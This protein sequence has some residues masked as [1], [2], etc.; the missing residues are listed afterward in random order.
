M[1]RWIIFDHCADDIGNK[2]IA[3]TCWKIPVSV[4]ST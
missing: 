4:S 2:N 1:V 3:V